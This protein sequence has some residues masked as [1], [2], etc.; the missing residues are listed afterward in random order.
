MIYFRYNC[1]FFPIFVLS[2]CV[3]IGATEKAVLTCRRRQCAPLTDS[4]YGYDSV[5]SYFY[6]PWCS[7]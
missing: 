7:A 1:S 4:V 5:F 2:V 3:S 6:L